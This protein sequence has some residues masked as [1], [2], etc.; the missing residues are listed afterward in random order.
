M[1]M[2]IMSRGC[3]DKE[4]IYHYEKQDEPY[5]KG[6]AFKLRCFLFIF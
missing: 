2:R 3:L 4:M 5:T 6:D 1:M